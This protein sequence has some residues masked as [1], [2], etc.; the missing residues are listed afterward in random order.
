MTARRTGRADAKAGLSDPAVPNGRAVAYRI[1]AT[2]GITGL[3]PPRVTLGSPPERSGGKQRLISV[4]PLWGNTEGRFL[5]V[6]ERL[7]NNVDVF[8]VHA[9]GTLSSV[10]VNQDA[11]PG[12]FAVT[13]APNG[14]ALV[15][16][17]GPA[18]AHNGSTIS[19]YGILD[20]RSIFPISAGLPTLGA[21][22]CWNAVTPDGR[23]VYTNNA[24]SSNISGFAIN[25]NGTLTA[26]PNTIQ[27]SN[28][29]ASANIDLPIS[30]GGK[31]LTA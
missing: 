26:L 9:D 12:T 15:V 14:A 20:D 29:N 23:F 19:S 1:K 2:L 16:E 18:G 10:A 25:G 8:S 13:F 3:S 11:L 7:T 31:F 24:G 4:K 22:T 6:T 28:P 27:A 30:S 5:V 21:A 17:T